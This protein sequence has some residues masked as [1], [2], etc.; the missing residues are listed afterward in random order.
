MGSNRPPGG[1][2]CSRCVGGLA[3]RGPL[4]GVLDWLADSGASLHPQMYHYSGLH[5]LY[6]GGIWGVCLKGQLGGAGQELPIL[7]SIPRILVGASRII[8]VIC[9]GFPL[10]LNLG[11]TSPESVWFWSSMVG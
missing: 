10:N 11:S 3:E 6:L 9:R 1:D 4:E 8:A 2:S 7:R 5:G